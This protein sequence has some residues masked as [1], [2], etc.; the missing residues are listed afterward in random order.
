[1]I[2]LILVAILWIAVLVPSVISKM[3]ERR[4]AGSIGR[5]HD[6]LDL[7]ERTGPKLVRPAYRLTGTDGALHGGAPIVVSTPPP[8]V[9]P[10]LT[11]VPLIGDHAASFEESVGEPMQPPILEEVVMH[12][13]ESVEDAVEA[14]ATDEGQPRDDEM[15]EHDR[16]A[17]TAHNRRRAARRRRRDVF[18]ALCALTA[19]TGLLGLARPLRGA[20][21]VSVVFF[22]LLVGFVALAM[23]GQRIE[24]ERRHLAQLQVVEQAPRFE[25][26]EFE[27]PTVKY[28]SEDELE[29]YYEALA[30]HYE[31]EHLRLAAQA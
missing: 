11:L 3:R 28:L 27:S 4:S 6:R 26:D 19:I 12:W 29:D 31:E 10:N 9:R 17:S 7:L 30:N 14:L 23:Y 24:A 21:V 16:R 22:V 15:T 25:G 2:V 13:H 8:P 5:F 1:V 20:W 18:A